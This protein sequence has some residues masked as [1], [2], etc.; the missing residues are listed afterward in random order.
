ME[1]ERERET[2]RERERKGERESEREE[3]RGYEWLHALRILRHFV[4]LA[5]PTKSLSYKDMQMRIE[6]HIIEIF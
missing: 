2:E 5:L 1:K 4:A 3:E 6:K